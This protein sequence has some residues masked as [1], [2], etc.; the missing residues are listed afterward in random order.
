MMQTDSK[1]PRSRGSEILASR[2]FARG[3]TRGSM[4]FQ[5]FLATYVARVH[6]A[7]RVQ[8]GEGGILIGWNLLVREFADE[9]E[10]GYMFRYCTG[11]KHR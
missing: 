7:L 9:V 1:A 10:V 3:R 11:N 6:R 2:L 5:G 4:S 8:K